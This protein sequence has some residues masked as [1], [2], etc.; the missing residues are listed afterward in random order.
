MQLL[1]VC[2][3][4]FQYVCDLNRR[5]REGVRFNL[6][7]VERE[8]E[9]V[10]KEMKSQ[11]AMT[12]AVAA[13]YERVELP[14]MFFVD[15]VICRGA[16]NIAGDWPRLAFKRKERNGDDDFFDK[17]LSRAMEENATQQLLVFYTCI[18]LGFV[19]KFS[20]DP[21]NGPDQLR[22]LTVE[23]EDKIR[24]I[25]EFG[26]G[27]VQPR[28]TAEAYE[29][30]REDDLIPPPVRPITKIVLLLV[31]LIIVLGIVNWLSYTYAYQDL[32]KA[33]HAS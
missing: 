26:G 9:D 23:I 3:P 25:P 29:Y 5:G 2:D 24:G 6:K 16:T 22:D 32:I 33:L 14:L 19:G 1:Q 10:F 7:Q 15:D 17:F 31:L 27:K 8:L 21:T 20:Y 13:D 4:V 12:P 28:I 18:G 11:A 30:T